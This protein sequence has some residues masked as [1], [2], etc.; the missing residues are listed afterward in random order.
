L[1]EAVPVPEGDALEREHDAFL[2]AVR[3]D[4]PFP[5]PGSEALAVLELCEAVREAL[6]VSAGGR[7]PP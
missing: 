3:G 5:V 4:G 6:R 1:G 2:A 7:S